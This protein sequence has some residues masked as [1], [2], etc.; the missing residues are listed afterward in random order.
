MSAD[1]RYVV[2]IAGL[3][4]SGGAGLAA[5]IKTL[6][7]WSV[8][9]LPVCSAITF[10]TEE[11][12][13]GVS[14]IA[15][16]QL[17]LQLELVLKRYQP[18][19][20]KIG[21][22]QSLDVLREV[23]GLVD[24]HSPLATVVWDPVWRASSGFV[25][26]P[27]APPQELQRILPRIGLLTPNAEEAKWLTRQEDP[28]E[29]AH[30]LAAY[31]PVLVK[32]IRRETDHGDLLIWKQKAYWLPTTHPLPTSKHGSGCVLSSAIAA[33]LAHGIPLDQ[34]CRQAKEYIFRFLQSSDDLLGTHAGT[35]MSN[36]CTPS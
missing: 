13:Y 24:Q 25:F 28:Q 14:W 6:E 31:C 34:A 29:A 35:V 33:A 4:P 30:L 18:H 1:R 9:G 20:V 8:H 27:Q 2:T 32:S 21:I 11:K 26:Q 19:V 16:H 7:Q 15:P 22:I 3:D 23:L 17:L 5:D 36:L 10:Q 12:V